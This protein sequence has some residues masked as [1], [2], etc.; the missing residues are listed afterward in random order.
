MIKHLSEIAPSYDHFIIDIFGVIHDGIRPFPETI[1]TLTALK[2]AGKKT[3]LLSNSPRLSAR[4]VEHMKSM[5][6]PRH[7][8]DY[9]VTSGEATHEYLDDPAFR[10]KACWFIG[11]NFIE[12]LADL[13]LSFTEGPEGADFI[14]NSIPGTGKSEV[15][16]LTRQLE[17]AAA[18]KIPMI[19]ANPDLVVNIGD[20]QHECAGTFAAIYEQMGGRVIYQGKPHREV[21]E[22]CHALLGQ[23]NKSRICAIGDSLHT[24]VAGANNFGISSAW[25]II[26]IH[27]EE[28]KCHHKPGEADLAKIENLI[29]SQPHKPD[30]V[31]KGFIW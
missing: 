14:L 5:G 23:P 17:T 24:D 7:L 27:W 30:Y 31:M 26:G 20:D 29:N 1:D 16:L 25:N 11:K 9:I 21:Y 28:L 13:G 18:N 6:I 22:T 10:H 4:A 12:D 19:C 15:A 3:C 8:Y 2:D